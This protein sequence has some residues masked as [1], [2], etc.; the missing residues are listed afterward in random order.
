MG[1]ESHTGLLNPLNILFYF[2][3]FL[4]APSQ[5]FAGAPAAC[6]AD[7]GAVPPIPFEVGDGNDYGGRILELTVPDQCRCDGTDCIPC[8]VVVGFHGYGQTGSGPA[9][10]KSRL[11]PKGAV[12]GFISLYPTGDNTVPHSYDGG[13][14]PNWAVPS[15]MAPGDGCLLD[16]GIPCDWCG[17]IEEDNDTSLQREIDFTKAIVKW[18]RENYCVDSQ[19]V[20]ATG[21]SNGAMWVHTLAR[22][23]E[24]ASLFKAFVP[25]DGIDQAGND[26][27]LRWITAPPG[28]SVPWILHINEVFDRFEPYDGMNYVDTYVD[29]G[30][31]VWIYP[32]I[33]QI[34]AE[35][36]DKN[37]AYAACGFSANDVADRYGALAVGGVVPEGY[38][39]LNGPGSLEG[40]GQQMLHCFT[41]DAVNER[42][43]KL[44]VCL[45]D[46]GD[47]GDD[48]TDPHGRA[49]RELSGGTDPGTAGIEPMDVMWRFMQRAV[50][51][52]TRAED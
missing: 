23:P 44:A 48:L 8:P 29:D 2:L 11:E 36:V 16:A 21:F 38:R 41:K 20:F 40:E 28:G 25:M 13:M 9:S 12:V 46:G 45:W 18:T 34:F 30:Y 24:T 7:S 14:S 26:D 15:C 32:S 51:T 39:R 31:P 43:E 1:A 17:N 42:C 4:I 3:I 52:K 49:G 35:Y 22:H 47:P 6:D 50:A 37:D 19:Q 27:V 33:L 10:W 5:A